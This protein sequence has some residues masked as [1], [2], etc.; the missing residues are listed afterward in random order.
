[1]DVKLFDFDGVVTRVMLGLV[2]ALTSL[3]Q[4]RNWLSGLFIHIVFAVLLIWCASEVI[5]CLDV[6]LAASVLLT[7]N[8]C[9][10]LYVT[11]SSV[12]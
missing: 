9:L 1:M 6:V 2:W 7:Y 10:T 12:I 5:Q 4:P 8:A 3:A 11:H